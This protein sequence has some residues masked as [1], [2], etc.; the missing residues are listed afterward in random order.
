MRSR[1]F[2]TLISFFASIVLLAW[3][4][5]ASAQEETRLL[6]F[7]N[8]NGNSVVFTY[9][10]DL[11]TASLNG[12]EAKR[13][14]SHEGQEV[15][16]RFSPDGRWI[17][18]SGEYG[19]TRQVYVIPSTGGTPRQLTFYPD[20]GPMPPRGGYD[21]LVLDWTP[22]GSKIMIRANRTPFGERVG[23]YYL[24][25]P[26]NGGLE[27]P[28]E[29]P[30][31]ASGATY[32]ET[33]TKL[34]YNIKSREWR[35]W[36]R[37]RAGRQQDVWIYDL[38]NHTADRVTDEPATDNFPMWIGKEIYFV[39]DRDENEKLNLWVYDTE[40][41]ETSQVT[42]HTEFDVMWPSRGVGGIVYENGG[43][44]YHFDPA[45]KE[46]R[47]LSIT[48]I[49][50][51]P[52]TVPYF[53]NVSDNVE[54]FDISPSGKRVVF[55]ARG[56]VFTVPAENGN[57]RNLSETPSFRERGVGWSPDGKWISYFSDASGDY[58]LYVMPSD[59]SAEPT[60]LV[61]GDAVWMDG[62][63]WSPD[64]KWIAWSDNM[65]RLRAMEVAS[66]RLVD[67]DRT[68]TGPLSDFSWA[69]D[70]K[71]IAYAKN[72]ANAM[73]SVWIYSFTSGARSQVTDDMTSESNP[74][75]DPKGRFLYFI[76]ARDFN[77][78]GSQSRF[79][80]RIYA[81]TLQAD[82]GQLFPPKSDEEPGVVG[83]GGEKAGGVSGDSVA[84]SGEGTAPFR[85]ELEGL[86]TRVM[87]LPE[88]S[89]GNYAALLP[90]EDG[91]L[92]F[93]GGAL[94]KY[95]LEDR[96]TAEII[97]GIN[98]FAITPDRKKIAYRSG[99]SNFGIVE[100]RPGQK[101]D[102]GR[103]DL[104]GMELRIDP[105]V[106]WAQI[107][108]D[109]W[110]LMED[111]FY[112][113]GMHGVDWDAMYRRYEPLVAHVAHRADLDYVIS[114]LIAE[115]NV[116]HA[117][118]TVTPEMPEVDRVEVALL[119]AEFQ[120][121]GGYYRISNIFPGEN[122]QEE[123]RSPLTVP[124]VDV[125]EGDYL[126]A[127]DG[128]EVT[129]AD[130]PYAFLVGKADRTVEIMFNSRPS[131]DGARSYTIEPITS[132]LGLRYQEWVERQAALVDSL[133]GG[134]IGYIHLPNTSQP[135]FREL[136]EGW[137]PLHLKEALILDDRYNGGGFIP[138]DMAFLVGAPLLNYWA[139]RNLDLYTQPGVVHTGPK[140]VLINGQSSSGGDAFPYYFRELGLGP[141][142][143]E[144][145]WGGL[146]GYSGNPGFVDGGGVIAPRFAFIDTDGNWAVEA[147][148]VAPDP[149]FEVLDRPEEIA[150]GRQPMIERAVEYL[151]QELQNPQYQRPEKPTGPI[152]R[153][154]GGGGLD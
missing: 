10:G 18:F 116:G 69:G 154:G 15:F 106:E 45:T 35:H 80:S 131:R 89:P 38:A 74:V 42:R 54:S 60:R 12:G 136:Y 39:S 140:A 114:E 7:P 21:H 120:A 27:L 14:T 44:L 34:A 145:T 143:G 22:D 153:P 128:E 90:T 107:Y 25:D 40:T 109:A 16:A 83:A 71:W 134:R 147:E 146:V 36:K 51:R 92:Y 29:I 30:E 4:G 148:G 85:V 95:T 62:L 64:S 108:H 52:Y 33:G 75:F 49:G 59:R 8:I 19:G 104:S 135:G 66:K 117:Y 139:Q 5:L 58:D 73:P 70:S 6:R 31:G 46:S 112:D 68:G 132:E 3:T 141:L 144:K 57:I 43:Y 20:V 96:K 113:P 61:P 79:Q 63:Q 56:E 72:G 86:G 133:S 130:N 65:N 11:Y 84:G 23:R 123:Y 100:V 41:G 87:A 127:I 137:Q 32:D 53:R 125:H 149:G 122:W 78:Q 138:E 55:G 152:R 88:I 124:G 111:W 9:A 17:A 48:V 105:K 150:A 110:V 97:T 103:L 26:V 98:G 82:Y 67:I 76:S 99:G 142:I 151:L 119:G 91:L 129:A 93:S 24:V 102:A 121:D 37:Y 115:L 28:L 81:A 50:D 77:Y 13:L 118:M 94:Q 126:I 1:S 47:K 2:Q 101:N